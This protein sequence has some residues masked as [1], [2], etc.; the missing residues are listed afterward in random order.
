MLYVL[1]VKIKTYT[2]N[3]SKI[4]TEYISS[5]SVFWCQVILF[6]SSFQYIQSHY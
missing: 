4:Y 3:T 1:Y 2:F 5:N 6:L